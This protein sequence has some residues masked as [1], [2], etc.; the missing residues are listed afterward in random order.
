MVR[1]LTVGC[2]SIVGKCVPV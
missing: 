2:V 1:I